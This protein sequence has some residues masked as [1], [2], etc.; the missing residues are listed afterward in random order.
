M[1]SLPT[2]DTVRI[3]LALAP[4]DAVLSWAWQAI[5]DRGLSAEDAA[6]ICAAYEL[7]KPR[8]VTATMTEAIKT[9]EAV[10]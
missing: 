7:S 10:G 2:P 6:Y 3:V 5:N 9:T 8:I 1:T 4:R